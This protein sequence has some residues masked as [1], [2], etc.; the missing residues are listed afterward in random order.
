[1]L[2]WTLGCMYLFVL[3]FLGGL[4]GYIPRSGIAGSYGSSIFS[5]LRNL[6]PVFHSDCTNLHSH[7]QC[8]RVPFSP[9]PC[10]NLLFLFFLMTAILTECAVAKTVRSS[11]LNIEDGRWR[12]SDWF[13]SRST[14]SLFWNGETLIQFLNAWS[15]F[16]DSI[17]LTHILRAEI[18]RLFLIINRLVDLCVFRLLS[19]LNKCFSFTLPDHMAVTQIRSRVTFSM[20]V[21]LVTKF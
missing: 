16:L 6:H 17:I 14:Y 5:F 10:Q 19:L 21:F 8:R 7:Q 13:I 1:M 4:F 2:L 12:G 20:W 15:V 9:H 3:V 18:G 11:G